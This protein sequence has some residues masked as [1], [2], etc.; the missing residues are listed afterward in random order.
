MRKPNKF[1]LFVRLSESNGT[2]DNEVVVDV[3]IGSGF[4]LEQSLIVAPNVK[5]FSVDFNLRASDEFTVK[6]FVQVLEN[7]VRR[8]L[9]D[10]RGNGICFGVVFECEKSKQ[11]VGVH[12]SFPPS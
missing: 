2:E 8:N 5:E 6:N 4:I 12:H 10:V 11:R 9:P 7:V 3:E 1:S